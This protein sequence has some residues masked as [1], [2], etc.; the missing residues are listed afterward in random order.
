MLACTQKKCQ[1]HSPTNTSGHSKFEG[2]GLLKIMCYGESQTVQ[3]SQSN[4]T[5]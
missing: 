4:C 1:V 3:L 5:I 2:N